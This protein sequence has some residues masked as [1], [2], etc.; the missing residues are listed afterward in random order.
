[1]DFHPLVRDEINDAYI[2]YE[3]QRFG[4]GSEFLDE[5]NRV[6]SAI[7]VNPAQYGFADD[8][9]RE[10]LLRRFPYAIYYRE[11]TSSVRVLAVF[12]A[13]RDPSDWQS[14]V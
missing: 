12:H 2:W 1:M 4:L 8:G 6:F 10:G 11:M 3:K 14:R 13:A 7:T 9:V 5:L